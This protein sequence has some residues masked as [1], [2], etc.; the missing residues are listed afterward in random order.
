MQTELQIVFIDL[1]KAYD[2]VLRQEGWRCMAEQGV[3]EK[4]VCL[5]KDTRGCTNT[6]QD[7]CRNYGQDHS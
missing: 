3:P 7:Q 6:S 2:R 5:V 1:E 4:C